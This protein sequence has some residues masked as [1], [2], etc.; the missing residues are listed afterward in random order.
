M[1]GAMFF[2]ET[3]RI[4]SRPFSHYVAA[5]VMASAE[6]AEGIQHGL[7]DLRRGNITSWE[8][9]KRELGIEPA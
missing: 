2:E 7:A 8:D 5:Y 1:P 3:E 4:T 9:V 6:F